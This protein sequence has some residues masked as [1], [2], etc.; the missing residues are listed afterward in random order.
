MVHII[1]NVIIKAFRI[2]T[3]FLNINQINQTQINVELLIN[4]IMNLDLLGL[5]GQDHFLQNMP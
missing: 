5:I 4:R 2:G 1:D 3:V